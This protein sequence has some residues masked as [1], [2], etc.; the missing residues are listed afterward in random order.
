MIKVQAY[1]SY[2]RKTANVQ[3]EYEFCC[4]DALHKWLNKPNWKMHKCP[5]CKEEMECQK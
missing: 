1:Q 3:D 4:W 5:E 2:G